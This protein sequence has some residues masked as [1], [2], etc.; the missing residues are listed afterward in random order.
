VE[1]TVVQKIQKRRTLWKY[2]KGSAFTTFPQYGGGRV[3]SR[4][5][6]LEE[7]QTID[8]IPDISTLLRIGHFY[9]ALTSPDFS[10]AIMGFSW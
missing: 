10:L 2:G 4:G 9:F 5:S 7:K 8:Y 1:T 3:M 6:V